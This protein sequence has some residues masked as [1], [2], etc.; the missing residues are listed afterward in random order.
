M[1]YCLYVSLQYPRYYR[2]ALPA[3]N[4][5]FY[6]GLIAKPPH[7]VIIYIHEKCLAL[8]ARLLLFLS[9]LSFSATFVTRQRDRA[10]IR[11]IADRRDCREMILSE[12]G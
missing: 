12:R 6:R 11:A 2:A 3:L 7:S 4:S 8:S 10:R 9:L 5:S 1:L